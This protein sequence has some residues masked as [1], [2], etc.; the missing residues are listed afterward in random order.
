MTA[1]LVHSVT[2]PE[3]GRAELVLDLPADHPAFAGHFPCQP[4]L[5]G[6]VQTHW[7]V[8]LGAEL[9][10]TGCEAATYFQVK[11]RR[12]IRPNRVLELS[13]RH[14]AAKASLS[15]EYRQGGEVAS[16]GRIKLESAR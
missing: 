14:D 10:E 15:F 5:P 6:V 9:L 4:V 12:I 16:T 8:R 3:P 1:P 11:F 7:A 2:R 13:L